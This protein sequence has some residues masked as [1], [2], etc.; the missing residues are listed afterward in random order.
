MALGMGKVSMSINNLRI[1]KTYVS[2]VLGP[3]AAGAP[4]SSS[5]F[6]PGIPGGQFVQ[7]PTNGRGEQIDNRGQFAPGIQNAGVYTASDQAGAQG[8][9]ITGETAQ[10]GGVA[11]RPG[12]I[13]A[14]PTYGTDFTGGYGPA[15]TVQGVSRPAESATGEQYSPGYTP[16]VQGP[17]YGTVS[18]PGAGQIA[19]GGYGPS[20]GQGQYVAGYPG[21]TTSTQFRPGSPQVGPGVGGSQLEQP[22]GGAQFGP[23]VGGSQFG[24]PTG[25]TQFGPGIGGT[26]LGQPTGGTQFG[27]N[28]ADTQLGQPAQY[29]TVAG[30]TQNGAGG[31]QFGSGSGPGA[32]GTQFGAGAGNGHY[33]PDG[34]VEGTQYGPGAVGPQQFPDQS[35]YGPGQVPG[36]L[37]QFG[38]NGQ[39]I[40]Q[41]HIYHGEGGYEVAGG[42][43]DDSDSEAQ[44]SV[45]QVN[46]ETQ[47]SAS[48]QGKFGGGTAQSQVQG[49]YFGTGS[50]TASAGTNDGRR[51][52][53]TLISGGDAGVMSSAQG[54]GGL[55][56]SQ[57]QV[58][59]SSET[60]ETTSNAQ[61]GGYNHGTNSQVQANEK[62]GMA[63]AQAN[64][65]GSTS[66]QAQIGF[67]PY[68]ENDTDDQE[69]PFKGGGSASA[70]GGTYS[71]Q[72]QSQ[73][74]GKFRFGIKYTGSAQSQSGSSPSAP[75]NQTYF[76]PFTPISF[77]NISRQTHSSDRQ[78]FSASQFNKNLKKPSSTTLRYEATETKISQQVTTEVPHEPEYYD[79]NDYEDYEDEEKHKIG[80]K[81]ITQTS[82][83]QKQHIILDPL[84]D[85]DATVH[86]AHGND[87]LQHGT[88]L[89]PG[90]HVPGSSGYRIPQGFRGKVISLANG[91]N[92]AALGPNS[93]AQSVTLK[94]GS[95]RVIYN[96]PLYQLG[97]RTHLYNGNYG[98][99][100]GYTY[101]PATYK[102]KS[103]KS[104]PNFVAITKS[105]T[106]SQDLYTGKKTPSVYY[107]QSST[108]GYFTNTC[109]FNGR[110]KVCTPKPKTNPDGSP[111]IC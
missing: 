53:Q 67:T 98:Y 101:Q 84:E 44:S 99:G 70:Q 56:Q 24:Q 66:S 86:Q 41:D 1:L 28:G 9:V 13:P 111:V 57:A 76:K 80:T 15:E 73:I 18:G 25:G 55:G 85:L 29:G 103:G 110:T 54:T 48:A 94:P 38:A 109:V 92:T 91:F 78:N 40:G 107:S 102:L 50:F 35:L 33:R 27:P 31:S 62:G 20:V 14:A 43:S 95:G 88:I 68:N 100:S 83:N 69:T 106:G 52:A 97:S 45:Q 93:Q 42:V 22:T 104:L 36:P 7:G 46:N 72:S 6:R 49:S 59:L 108:C 79:D 71:G 21:Q 47:A 65:P 19:E 5:Q 89:Q 12:Y 81:S 64:G 32:G 90:Q 96:R 74:T 87:E 10:S 23:G 60:G 26:Q 58:S 82:G 16:G 75:G 11:A 51:G 17:A 37:Q 77:P 30:T 8:G 63:D 2:N 61:S 34:G 105:E 4:S 39:T 3:P